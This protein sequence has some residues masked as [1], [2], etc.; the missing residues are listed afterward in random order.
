MLVG[1]AG[2]SLSRADFYEKELSFQVSCSYGP[3]RYDPA[4]EEGGHDYPFAFVRWTEQRNFEAVL[5][6]IA[7]QRIDTDR[8][9]THRF[10]ID[11]AE[12][13]YD[14][15]AGA[16]PSLGIVLE[17]AGV[18]LEPGATSDHAA[19]TTGHADATASR[20]TDKLSRTLSLNPAASSGAPGKIT[21]GAIGAGNYASAVLLP[22]FKEAGVVLGVVASSGGVTGA[23][24]ARKL[25]FAR[26]TTDADAVIDDP[27]VDTIVI[28]TRHDSHARFIER[29]L[30]AGKHVF[31]EKPL[32]LTLD[33]LAQIE[34]THARTNAG[35]STARLLMV[36]FSRRFAPQVKRMKAL[37]DARPGPKSFVLTANAGAIPIEHWT[38]DEAVGGGRLIGEACHFVD[39]LRFLAGSRIIEQGITRMH[40]RTADTF[41][42]SLGFADGSIGT[43]HY[44]ANGSKAFPKE[45]LEVFSGGAILQL[46]NFRKLTGFGW[47]GFRSMNLFRQDKGQ[48]ACVKAFVDAANGGAALAPIPFDELTEVARTVIELSNP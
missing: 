32:C 11:Q 2:L 47:P 25:G 42:L 33:E 7:D 6:M 48:K 4:Y 38:Q 10:A 26:T 46:D 41:S 20:A 5:D 24:V 1:V 37:L 28:A 13:A 29:A 14:I 8:L 40:T 21:I 12:A 35:T 23:H 9:I 18:D 43:I 34:S 30:Q 22:A 31:V 17:Y 15:V 16:E 44:F 19:S 36:G 27:G 45:R 39:L 3:G